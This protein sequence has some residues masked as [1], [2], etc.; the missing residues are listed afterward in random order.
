MKNVRKVNDSLSRG[1]VRRKREK[2]KSDRNGTKT[3]D[4]RGWLFRLPRRSQQVPGL[5]H[6]QHRVRSSAGR[7]DKWSN[8][9][10]QGVARGRLIYTGRMTAA[11]G[12]TVTSIAPWLISPSSVGINLGGAIPNNGLPLRAVP[13]YLFPRGRVRVATGVAIIIHNT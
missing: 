1:I 2:R 5:E 9:E 10:E 4:W 13:R 6:G 3:R 11:D 7:F 12:F 8:R